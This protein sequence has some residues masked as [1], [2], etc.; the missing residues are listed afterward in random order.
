MKITEDE[1]KKLTDE[2]AAKRVA[3]MNVIK[4]RAAIAEGRPPR[5]SVGNPHVADIDAAPHEVA[6]ILLR[7]E[8]RA[9]KDL[10]RAARELYNV[11]GDLWDKAMYGEG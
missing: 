9:V 1:L 2:T 10:H 3:L 4:L 11:T 5:I 6:E 8:H 7:A